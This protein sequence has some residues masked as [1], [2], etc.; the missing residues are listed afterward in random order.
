METWD[1]NSLDV[2]PHRPQVLS[3]DEETRLVAI[4][5]PGGEEMQEHQTHERTYL[6]VLDGQVEVAQDGRS[7]GG[8]RGFVAHFEPNERRAGAGHHRRPPP[9]RAGSVARRGPPQS[10]RL[11][12]AEPARN[13]LPG[14]RGALP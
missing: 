8:G 4:N 5:L 3:S 6:V 14:G 1:L 11:A 13:T 12:A 2:P 7:T 10:A 9:A